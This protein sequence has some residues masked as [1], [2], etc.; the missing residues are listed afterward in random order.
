MDLQSFNSQMGQVGAD[1][2][3]KLAE[4]ADEVYARLR[5]QEH[6]DTLEQAPNDAALAQAGMLAMGA[7]QLP[8][9]TQGTGKS[10]NGVEGLGSTGSNPSIAENPQ[11]Q[12]TMGTMLDSMVE[13]AHKFVEASK[14]ANKKAAESENLNHVQTMANAAKK[15]LVKQEMGLPPG[16]FNP[17]T[18]T[19][20]TMAAAGLTVKGPV[21]PS[22]P[23][24]AGISSTKD[25]ID[26]ATPMIPSDMRA[27]LG[28]LGAL[29]AGAAALQANAL[30]IGKADKGADQ[31]LNKDF[32]GNY[33]DRLLK[34]I[35]DKGFDGM[36]DT[37]VH[38]KAPGEGRLS[39]EQ[40]QAYKDELKLGLL[41]SA[42]AMGYKADM[43]GMSGKEVMAQ[44]DSQSYE[45]AG[46]MA[47]V[48]DA[49]RQLFEKLPPGQEELVKERIS[50]FLDS[51]PKLDSLMDPVKV[52]KGMNAG[53]EVEQ[54]QGTRLPA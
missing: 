50:N 6:Q 22:D 27:E 47:P 54:Q 26:A 21:D 20:W 25:S 5:D 24:F 10:S 44:I 37:I 2:T 49:I 31:Q 9:P 32:A 8:I 41:V 52:F 45:T 16:F 48:L 3:K 17:Q 36:L 33:A 19:A 46:R 4:G 38:A 23:M 1:A 11:Y 30:T 28:Q 35:N 51:N 14:A 29:L 15:D 7:P 12:Q 42:F 39:P 18:V 43:G 13:A 53:K 34:M 40:V